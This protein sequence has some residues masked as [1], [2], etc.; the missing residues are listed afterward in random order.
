MG[1]EKHRRNHSWH[2]PQAS[3]DHADPSNWSV[4]AFSYS[5]VARIDSKS[6]TSLLVRS[7]GSVSKILVAAVVLCS[8]GTMFFGWRIYYKHVSNAIVLQNN[9]RTFGRAVHMG[10]SVVGREMYLGEWDGTMA[11]YAP[12]P[13]WPEEKQRVVIFTGAYSHIVDG[14]SL[15]LN[16]LVR[17]LESNGHAALI[18]APT[19]QV[20]AVKDAA[21]T[22]L[23]APSL[24]VPFRPEYRLSLSLTPAMEKKVAEFQPTLIQIATPDLLGSEAMMWALKNDIPIVCSYHTRF[25]SYLQYYGLGILEG[26]LWWWLRRFYSGCHHIYPPSPQVGD[27]LVMVGLD[28]SSIRLWP[29]GVDIEHFDPSKRDMEFRRSIGVKDDELILLF[30]SR[31][32]LEKGLKIYQN[33]IVNLRRLNVPIRCVIVGEGPARGQLESDLKD[34]DVQ[35]LGSRNGDELAVIYASSDLFFFPS[36]TEGWGNVALEA[37]ASGL[38]VIGSNSTGTSFL[39]RDGET[40]FVA[41]PHNALSMANSIQLLAKDDALRLKMSQASRTWAMTFTWER[42]FS[43]LMTHYAEIVRQHDQTVQGGVAGYGNEKVSKDRLSP[44]KRMRIR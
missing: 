17:F 8:I 12:L 6:W 11:A 30:V 1:T 21:G 29:R 10:T 41:E 2:G 42:A 22:I 20:P 37:M 39:V 35:F 9:H 3:R 34:Y 40:G 36:T 24:S 32:V 44:S 13:P 4:P 23:S 5:K 38:P 7:F 19:S 27:E 16:H 31:L 43:L 15:T 18:V 33:A 25:N 28:A 26:P 14:V